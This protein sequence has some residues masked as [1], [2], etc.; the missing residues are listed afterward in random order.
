MKA[1]ELAQILL[2]RPEAEVFLVVE[3]HGQ[4]GT[5]TPWTDYDLAKMVGVFEKPGKIILSQD[6]YDAVGSCE[7]IL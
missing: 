5:G 1:K 3:E 2:S 7:R 4:Y 6:S